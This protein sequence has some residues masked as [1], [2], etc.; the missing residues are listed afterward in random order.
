[1]SD[2]LP[3]GVFWE[4]DGVTLRCA[5]I[6]P[7]GAYDLLERVVWGTTGPRFQMPGL[8]ERIGAMTDWTWIAMEE[9]DALVGIYGL[10]DIPRA[11]NGEM[12]RTLYRSALAI[13]PA[14]LHRKLGGVLVRET[15][16]FAL[17]HIGRG[18]VFGYI[19]DANAKSLVLSERV[20]YRREATVESVMPAWRDP[21]A[22]PGVRRLRDDERPWFVAALDAHYAGHALADFASSV[23][24]DR[25]W[26][27]EEGG[28][29][30]AALMADRQRWIVEGI[31]S[32]MIEAVLPYLP[33]Y[34]TIMD[35]KD[36]RFL[37]VQHL[38]CAPGR[39]ADLY[40][41]IEGALHAENAKISV[42]IGDRSS[43]VWQAFR[44]AGWVGWL[45]PFGVDL[46]VMAALVG[47][48]PHKGPVV[49]TLNGV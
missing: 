18:V 42:I 36:Y 41:L 45:Y 49:Y 16:A 3:E 28:A 20:G 40:R 37:F 6:V 32:P 15:R 21:K 23:R 34:G 12:V 30:V 47:V 7:D 10:H 29:P 27:L 11:W 2:R 48:D 19:E 9:G 38:W 35:L 4:R 1:V 24:T 25:S 8:R 31:G 44:K 22:V 14:H 13:D 46:H 5:H 26:V 33:V 43:P 39:D 17:E